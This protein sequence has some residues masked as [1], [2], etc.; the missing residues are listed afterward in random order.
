[1]SLLHD[2]IVPK[3]DL[4]LEL[5]KYI[6]LTEEE[7]IAREVHATHAR[8]VSESE[9]EPT[10]RRQSGI[11]F[12]DSFIVSKKR[13]SDSTYAFF[14]DSWIHQ[15][16]TRANLSFS[17]TIYPVAIVAS[18]AVDPVGSPSS[19][20]IDQDEQSTS[21]SPTNQEIQSQVTHQGVEE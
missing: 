8:I 11:A 5:G 21:T 20:T 18:R 4:A 17:N 9:S 7:A 16:R 15:F 14:D 10:Q 2:N 1:R 12:R 13:S 19:T 6:S 3:L